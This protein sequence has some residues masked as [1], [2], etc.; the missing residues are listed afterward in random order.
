ML[1]NG[2]RATIAEIA[3]AETINQ[4]YIAWILRMILLAPEIIEESW[5]D[6]RRMR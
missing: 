2:T 5:K 1:E 3:S 4:S 6:G